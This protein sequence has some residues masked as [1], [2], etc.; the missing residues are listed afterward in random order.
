MKNK[1]VIMSPY[2]EW[3]I[4][5]EVREIQQKIMEHFAPDGCDV[6]QVE[7]PRV[8]Y[9]HGPSLTKFINETDYEIYVFFNIDSIP[10]NKDIIPRLIK[11]AKAGKLIGCMLRNGSRHLFAG[12]CGMA[13][14]QELYD[15]C[16]VSFRRGRRDLE[17]EEVE[18]EK[19]VCPWNLREDDIGFWI[20]SD[21]GEKLT[22]KCEEYG[23][24]VIFLKPTNVEE[25]KFKWLDGF[26][27]GLGN[28]F[29]KDIWHQAETWNGTE[30]LLNKMKEVW[31]KIE[32]GD[33]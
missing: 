16:K 27:L 26:F 30:R 32:S 21:T 13:F 6:V 3:N 24:P 25:V 17:P 20:E 8:L 23:I 29:E 9:T 19:K 15:K 28:T 14:S 31:E 1:I 18:K 2:M 33:L 7:M 5:K 4:S 12:D 22:Y 11:E 10:L